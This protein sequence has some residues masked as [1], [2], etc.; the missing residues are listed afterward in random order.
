MSKRKKKLHIDIETVSTDFGKPD[1]T[2]IAAYRLGNGLVEV[3]ELGSLEPGPNVRD[4]I[5]KQINRDQFSKA[6][7]T[8][9]DSRWLTCPGSNGMTEAELNEKYKDQNESF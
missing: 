2:M 1:Q 8:S 4:F 6:K 5:E 3:V 9:L 7:P